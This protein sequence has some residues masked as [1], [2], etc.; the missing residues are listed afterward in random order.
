MGR[1]TVKCKDCLAEGVATVRPTP[2]G[3]PRSPL[4]TTHYRARRKRTKALRHGLHVERRYGITPAEYQALLDAQGGRCA[5]CGKAKGIS[6]MLAVDHEHGK[7]GCD[8]PPEVGCHNCVRCLA[9]STCNTVVLGRYSVEA[10]QRA[11]DV[12]TCPPAQRILQ[13]RLRSA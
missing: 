5:V 1:K 11:I 2:H 10:L 6:K 13:S 4:C 3:G 7:P 12:L 9:C 8:H